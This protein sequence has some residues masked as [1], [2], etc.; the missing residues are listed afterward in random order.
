MFF[1]GVSSFKEERYTMKSDEEVVIMVNDGDLQALEYLILKYKPLVKSK[2]YNYYIVGA[3]K[4]DIIQEGMIGLYKAIK[5]F[6]GKKSSSFK[7]FAEM[8]VTNQII[9]AIKTATRQKHIPLNESISLNKPMYDDFSKCFIIDTIE[10]ETSQDPM[11]LFIS[12]EDLNLME[13]KIQGLLSSLE[14][15][16]LNNYLEG[17]TYQEIGNI[18][19]INLKCI[20]NTIQ[21]I[22]RKVERYIINKL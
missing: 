22:K 13:K 2:V 14:R 6:D 5:S 20:D 16:V 4:D 8:C 1:S 10:S 7:N 9:T 21:R 17:K 15:N 11:D 19:N 3:D 18:L 12:K